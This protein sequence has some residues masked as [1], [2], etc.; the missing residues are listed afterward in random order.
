MDVIAT[1]KVVGLATALREQRSLDKASA[2]LLRLLSHYRFLVG[3]A[4]TLSITY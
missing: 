3:E 4:C 2:H 1:G